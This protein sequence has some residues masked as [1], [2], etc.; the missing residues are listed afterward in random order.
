M[1]TIELIQALAGSELGFEL[2]PH[3][4]TETA[5]E[6]AAALVFELGAVPPFGGPMGDRVLVDRRIAG[7][8]SVVFEAGSHGESIRMKTG[9]LLRLSGGEV[10]DVCRD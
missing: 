1:T 6:E 8:E 2:L 4:R 3:Q 9:N 7:R 10:A 5:S